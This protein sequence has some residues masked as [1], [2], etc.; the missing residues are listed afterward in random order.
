MEIRR[1]K[2]CRNVP[3]IEVHF[4]GGRRKMATHKVCFFIGHREADESLFPRLMEEIERHA[5]EYGVSEFVIG[6]YGNFDRLA[7]RA[8]VEVKKRHQ[9]IS[10]VRLLPYHPADRPV[11]IPPGFDS[12]FYPPGLELVPKRLAIVRANCYMVDH[13]DY[14]IAYAWHPASNALELVEYAQKREQHR[15]IRVTLLAEESRKT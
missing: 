2:H 15:L 1:R 7:S 5:T 4:L 12:T 14:L 13:S 8:A 11:H 9:E 10:L 6:N 3:Q